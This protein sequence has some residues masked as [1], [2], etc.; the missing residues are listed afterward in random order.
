MSED[1][2]K[3]IFK[4]PTNGINKIIPEIPQSQ[5]PTKMASNTDNA[6]T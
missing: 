5:P 3:L 6:F 4:T 1:F 2:S